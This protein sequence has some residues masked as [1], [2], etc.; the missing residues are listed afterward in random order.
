LPKKLGEILPLVKV[1]SGISKPASSREIIFE[2][3]YLIATG[4][5][6]FDEPKGWREVIDKMVSLDV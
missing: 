5:E 4:D 3:S 6:R 1:K 2:T